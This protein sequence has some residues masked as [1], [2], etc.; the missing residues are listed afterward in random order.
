MVAALASVVVLFSGAVVHCHAETTHRVFLKGTDSELDV[1]F[2][3]GREPGPTLLLVG[4]IQGNEPGGYL[5]ADL[6]ADIS[7]K[8]G[9]LIVVPRANFLSIV[10][11]DRGVRG[12]MNRKFASVGR[13][14][15]QDVRVVEIIKDLMSQS[16]AFLNLHDGSGFYSPT[17]ESRLCNPMRYGQS[18]IADA[19]DYARSDGK[20]LKLGEI[21]RRI[22]DK[23]N[24]QIADARHLFRFNNHRTAEAD[25]RH[26]EQRLSATYYALT[27]LGIPAFGIETSKSIPDYR[28]RVR[29]QTMV[30]NAFLEEFGIVL[31]NPKVALDSPFLKYLIVTVNERTPTVVTGN[32]V[33]KVHKGDR[34]RIVHIESN[35]SRGLTAQVKG[36]GRVLN[37]VD[38]EIAISENTV[39]H[40]RKDR[41]LIATIPVEIMDSREGR[42]SAGIHFEPRVTHF[43]VRVNDRTYVVEPGEE[44]TVLRGDKLVILDPKTNLSEEDEKGMRIDLRGFQ[45][46]S[47]PYPVEDRGHLIHTD[48]DL[49][50]TYG[51]VRGPVT[52]FMLQAKLNRKVFGQCYIAVAEPRLEY[53]VLKGSRGAGFIVNSGDKL[54]VPRDEVLRIVDVRTNF[55]EDSPLFITMS[56]RTIRWERE[57][58][59]GIDAAKLSGEEVP[60]DITRNGR[61]LGRIW[62]KQGTEYR[63]SSGGKQPRS[64]LIPVNYP[65]G[66]N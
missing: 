27:S 3:K 17:W 34:V 61:S 18:I 10:Q 52:F 7:L 35:Y 46:K 43:C 13:R 49:Q 66:A 14:V 19:D 42:M 36:S 11:D 47:S 51:Q 57:G 24:P 20:I 22:A 62:V 31:E 60:L 45:A 2:I 38:R 53:L 33:L 6:Y 15:D 16:D 44:L 56:G 28:L 30:I 9:N 58:Q 26:K 25:T 59:A 1:Y 4:G 8:K 50:D 32:D 39:I 29:Y 37:Y 40:V 23:V 63:I 48:R 12:D 65:G 64:P 5:A 21:A 41:F 55:R 54:E